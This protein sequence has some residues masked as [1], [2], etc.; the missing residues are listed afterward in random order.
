MTVTK[1]HQSQ[2]DTDSVG[3]TQ[4]VATAVTPAAYTNANITVD[5]DGR[6][7]SAA[8]GTAI[9][10]RV[11]NE[12]PTGAVNGTNPTFTLA[13]TPIAGTEEIHIDGIQMFPG[14]GND[15]TIAGA[16]I[17]MLTTSIPATGQRISANYNY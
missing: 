10:T 1:I 7:T 2:L 5:A 13:N 17:T 6:V 15:Y 8:N 12:A 11:A 9:P 3:P 4:L 14:A 16:V